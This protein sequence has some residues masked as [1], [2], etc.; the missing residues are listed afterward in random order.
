MKIDIYDKIPPEIAIKIKEFD[1]GEMS[2]YLNDPF[3]FTTGVISMKDKIIAA[4]IIRVVNELKI[5][6]KLEVSDINKAMAISLLFKAAKEKMQCNE[7]FALITQGGDHYVNILK[8][9]YKFYEDHGV[10][11]R[12]ERGRNGW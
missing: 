11:L 5:T 1:T 8:N 12:L 9:H 2:S 10:F 4:G 3:T 6:A 7:A